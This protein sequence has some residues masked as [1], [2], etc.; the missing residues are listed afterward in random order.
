M[1]PL[2]KTLYSFESSTHAGI[3]LEISIFVPIHRLGAHAR[4]GGL[5]FT[6][7]LFSALQHV[8]DSFCACVVMSHISTL[9]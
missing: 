7:S 6:L 4:R 2:L 3:V 8:R 9:F 5:R 1:T